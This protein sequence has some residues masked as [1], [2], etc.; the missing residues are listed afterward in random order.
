MPQVELTDDQIALLNTAQKLGGMPALDNMYRAHQVHNKLYGDPKTRA[1]YEG[2]IKQQFPTVTTTADVAAPYV[3]RINAVEK[4]FNEFADNFVREKANQT[5]QQRQEAFNANWA[6]MVKDHDLTPEGEEAMAKYMKDNNLHDPESAALRY[7]KH[8]PK[9]EPIQ[10]AGGL[11]PQSWGIGPLPG[12]D[13][14]DG[15]LLMTEPERWADKEAFATL[16]E[17]RRTAA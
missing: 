9:P 8:N 5:Q 14:A 6:Q 12:E 15:K 1:H 7:F 13:E 16:N 11:S 17:I 3:E 2:L 10:P 4:K